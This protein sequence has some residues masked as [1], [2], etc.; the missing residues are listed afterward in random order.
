VDLGIPLRCF[1]KSARL[2]VEK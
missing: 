2:C 1:K